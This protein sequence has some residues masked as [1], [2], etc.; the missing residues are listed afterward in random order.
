MLLVRHLIT[1]KNLINAM[2]FVR[3][4]ISKRL[5]KEILNK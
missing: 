1:R 2:L 4:L 5:S 3:Y